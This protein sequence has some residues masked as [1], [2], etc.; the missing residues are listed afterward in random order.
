VTRRGRRR[1]PRDREA[2]AGNP[3]TATASGATEPFVLE[4]P[5]STAAQ[6]T[7]GERIT[8]GPIQ[9]TPGRRRRRA[10]WPWP[11]I[12]AAAA[13]VIPAL[14]LLGGAVW[15]VASNSAGLKNL[16]EKHN[17]LITKVGE[18]FKELKDYIDKRISEVLRDRQRDNEPP[19]R[20]K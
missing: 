11:T 2:I 7:R 20:R 16:E 8:L 3:E 17:A 18:N 12:W 1:R 19:P 10:R 14:A 6:A 9:R 15:V 5:D 4:S 13:A